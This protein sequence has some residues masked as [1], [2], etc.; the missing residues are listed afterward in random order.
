MYVYGE[1]KFADLHNLAADPAAGIIGRIYWNTV[2]LKAMLDDG[3]TILALLRND[4]KH[5]LGTN[6]TAASNIRTNRAAAAVLQFV[7]GDDVT[8]EG[9]LSTALAKLSFK[10]ESYATGSLPAAAAAG[11]IAWDTTTLTPKVDNGSAWINLIPLT[12]KGDIY[13]FSTVPIRLGV[14]TDTQYLA[15]ASGQATGL[16]WTTF[17]TTTKGDIFTFST[18]LAALPV[19]TNGY[20]LTASSGA[21]TGLLWAALQIINLASSASGGVTG[22]LPVTNLNSGTSASTSTFWR[23]D[24]TWSVLPVTAQQSV[25]NFQNFQ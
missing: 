25:F 4:Q 24:G 9:S 15:A 13:G 18:V 12:T 21:A 22:N 1:L 8:A 7:T 19:G 20:Y 11:R 6:G 17:P 2:S 10:F 3:T 16:Q 14:G 23:G 5:I